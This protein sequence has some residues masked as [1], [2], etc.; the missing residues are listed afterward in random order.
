M[1]LLVDGETIA[2]IVVHTDIKR[3][4]AP[5]SGPA[6]DPDP[7]VLNL[8]AT[9]VVGVASA[10]AGAH[11]ALVNDLGCSGS[12][13]PVPSG[14]SFPGSKP[15]L[16]TIGS[17]NLMN[18]SIKPWSSVTPSNTTWQK[19]VAIGTELHY[20][21]TICFQGLGSVQLKW[22]DGTVVTF[23]DPAVITKRGK[24]TNCM[25]IG[26]QR[27]ED[28]VS[29]G[30]IR[31]GA[32]ILL[33]TVTKAIPG[34]IRA[35][36]E[37]ATP[38]EI[39]EVDV[40]LAVK[41]TTFVIGEDRALGASLV[42]AED[43]VVT[44]IPR[45]ASLAP[46]D[47]QP[48]NQVRVTA[49]SIGPITPGC[50]LPSAAPI[51]EPDTSASGMTLQAARRTVAAGSSVLI[52]VWL[53][54]ADNLANL[55]FALTYDPAVVQ[56]AGDPVKGDLLDNTLFKANAGQTGSVL[57]GLAQTSPLRGTGTVVNIPF[58]A[59]GQPG[60]VTELLLSVTSIND[61]SGGVLTI[62]RIAG[63]IT[64]AGSD[65]RV[66]GGPGSTDGSAPG[67]DDLQ[68]GDCDGDG[69]LTE[70]DALCAL[71]MST[72]LRPA[73]PI[74]DIDNSGSVDSRDSVVILQKALGK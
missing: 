34:L 52:P 41:G 30:I 25:E 24:F 13:T 48:G 2:T 44:V 19:R 35:V 15:V 68:K 65:G 26:V 67:P 55:N 47:L 62:N 10:V 3:P 74:M 73:N 42:C 60:D 69:S 71:E 50:T 66:P 31:N 4:D 29:P 14:N 8:D 61:P 49:S 40:V 57:A 37:S 23:S 12:P 59:T 45:N 16:A 17:V 11:R 46:F 33:D 22:N 39:R 20:G 7:K 1:F 53:I 38:P 21:D 18:V 43:H 32:A 27:P 70:L 72:Q 56:T 51:K 28:I 6:P 64:I 36:I 5:A 54:N 9:K 58:R 63:E